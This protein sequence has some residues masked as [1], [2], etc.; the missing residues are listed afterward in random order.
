[1][2]FTITSA[3]GGGLTQNST[4]MITGILVTGGISTD[5]FHPP[6]TSAEVVLGLDS[7][8]LPNLPEHRYD[9]TMDGIYL[10]GGV[11]VAVGS[12]PCLKFSEGQWIPF[13][14][15][16]Q[17]RT[18]HSSWMTDQGLVLMGGH[19]SP[20]T[21]EIVPTMEGHQGGLAFDMKYKTAEACSIPDSD[22]VL[23]TGG[24]HSLSSVSRYD[25]T[26]WL[27]D[28]PNLG[29]ER[30]RH[31]CGS[32]TRG[33]GTKAFLVAGGYDQ[34]TN[35][36]GDC[37]SPLSSTEVFTTNSQ[38][39]TLTT[40]LPWSLP[41]VRGVPVGGTLYMTGGMA[42]GGHN[43]AEVLAWNDEDEEWVV[44][45]M[46]TTARSY[47]GATQITDEV[48]EKFCNVRA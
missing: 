40:P 44:S 25:L 23:I 39:W 48:D 26:G 16:V 46:L 35:W 1:V 45:G 4:N 47:H 33:D 12:L 6:G 34:C 3:Y 31:G 15:L 9:H 8:R 11:S 13:Y 20:L 32:Y 38:V 7:C 37:S 24:L 10:C 19:Q 36:E 5:A 41:G 14:D 28:L 27:E 17:S 30:R 2:F 22:S 29:Q 21:S 43:R 42:N 18:R